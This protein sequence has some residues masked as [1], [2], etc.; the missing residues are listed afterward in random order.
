[1][2]LVVILSYF[3]SDIFVGIAYD[4]GGVAAGTMTATFLLP[5]AQ[6]TAEYMPSA[7]VVTDGFGV[8][9]I[10]ALIPLLTVEILGLIYK[11]SLK[12]QQ[13]RTAVQKVGE[14]NV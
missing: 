6:G 1:M 12:R 13:R 2:A 7:S 9:T 14:T 10:V 11:I 3:I 5:Y 8:I 4:S